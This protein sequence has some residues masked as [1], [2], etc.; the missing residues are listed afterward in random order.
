M[1]LLTACKKYVAEKFDKTR[2]GTGPRTSAGQARRRLLVLRG[3]QGR[4]G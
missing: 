4:R 2:D 3:I 1:D